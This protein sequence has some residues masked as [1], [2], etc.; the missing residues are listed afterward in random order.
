[1]GL[2][3]KF[4]DMDDFVESK[5]QPSLGERS[6]VGNVHM[7]KELHR[8]TE[9]SDEDSDASDSEPQP[10]T[11]PE[12]ILTGAKCINPPDMRVF[13]R[14][15]KKAKITWTMNLH[16]HECPLHD[17]GPMNATILS[18]LLKLYV[19]HNRDLETVQTRLREFVLSMEEAPTENR[20]SPK[21]PDVAV[22]QKQTARAAQLKA[23]KEEEHR[24]SLRV[25]TQLGSI[26]KRQ[27]F[28][29]RYK[30]HLLQYEACRPIIQQIEK[31]C[32]PGECVLF[33]DFVNQYMC[34]TGAKLA[35]LVLVVVWRSK[36]GVPNKCVSSFKQNTFTL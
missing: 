14:V 13:F 3:S 2:G 27:D 4:M 31:D 24:A 34:D 30:R 20:P 23:L 10:T 33:R 26:R 32:M 19:Q 6:M 22:E 18:T 29:G 15:L 5:D 28:D 7:L 35:N 21:E 11:E 9:V 1:M 25:S 36:I 8:L 16:P 17:Q 12:A